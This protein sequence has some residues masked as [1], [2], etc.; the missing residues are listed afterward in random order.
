MSACAAVKPYQKMYLNDEDMQLKR[1]V[2]EEH[3]TSFQ[4]YRKA[5][6]GAAGGKMG[7]GNHSAPHIDGVI[8]AGPVDQ[9]PNESRPDVLIFNSEPLTEALEV[10][11]PVTA[12][13]YIVSSACDTDFVVRLIDVY[14]DG[15][16]YNLTEGILRARFRDSIWEPPQ[17]LEPGQAYELTVDMMAT[18]NVFLLGHRIRVHVTSS[19]FPLWDRNPNTG[20]QQGGD[21][22]VVRAQQTIHCSPQRPSHVLLSAAAQPDLSAL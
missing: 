12:T 19:N 21:A 5:A 9:R 16:A 8:R 2:L 1:S 4:T 13:L 18:S 3:E 6:A 10:S 11:G 14:P 7:G 20:H 15:T 17:L 22:E